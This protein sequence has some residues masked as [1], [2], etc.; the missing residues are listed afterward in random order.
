[1]G[2]VRKTPSG[3]YELCVRNKKLLGSRRVYLTFPTEEAAN[4]YGD[5]VDKLLNAGIVPPGLLEE[6]PN[7]GERLSIIL[8]GWINSGDA[9][10]TE[11]DVLVL[12]RDEIG[13]T[14][15]P[16][17]T[18]KW[19]EAWVRSM[20][21]EK[22]YAPGTIRKRIGALSRCLDAYLRKH[23][24]IQL[25]NPLRLLP[26]GAASYNGKDAQEARK[27]GKDA[28]EDSVRERRL[29]AGEFDRI[30]RALAGEK[31][32]DRERPLEL[33]EADALRMLFLLVYY[34]GIRLREA[35]TLTAGQ[36][37]MRDRSLDI[38][39]S[40]QWYGR[41]KMRTVPMRPQLHA[42]FAH[43]LSLR[44]YGPDEPIFPW[45]DGTWDAKHLAHVTVKLS[46]QFSRIFEY[47][48]CVDLTEH[49]LRHEATCQWYELRA[50]DGH[51]LYREQEI[52]RIMG[53]APNSKMPARYASFRAEDLAQRMY[54]TEETEAPAVSG[55]DPAQASSPA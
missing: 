20:K 40:K 10:P 36:V 9:A 19:A 2:S 38:R 31:R 29:H 17:L 23:P 45:W 5:Q 52:P 41:V 24:E 55:P 48:G 34:S 32:D 16:E 25:G 6:T 33:K 21:L 22:N 12:L 49:D 8:Q 42:A 35:Y 13:A 3:S 14:R 50:P 47:A 7:P 46:A 18:Y 39:S 1:V 53:W 27:L 30:V 51:W 4:K 26:R 43:Y 54:V 37:R 15:L 44:E 28:K 11:V